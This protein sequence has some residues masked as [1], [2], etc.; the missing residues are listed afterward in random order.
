MLE[1]YPKDLNE[2]INRLS[3]MLEKTPAEAFLAII[4]TINILAQ[5]C[6]RLVSYDQ[7]LSWQDVRKAFADQLLDVFLGNYIR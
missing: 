7:D 4:H 1:P 2:Q 3:V 6:N 5:E